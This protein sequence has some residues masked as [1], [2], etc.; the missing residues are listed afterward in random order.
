MQKYIYES[1]NDFYDDINTNHIWRGNEQ[2]IL[3]LETIVGIV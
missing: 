1:G 3:A 2:R